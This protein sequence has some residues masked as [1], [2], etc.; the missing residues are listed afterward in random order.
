MNWPCCHIIPSS[1]IDFIS[2][3]R[4]DRYNRKLEKFH[5]VTAE[6]DEELSDLEEVERLKQCE[7]RP[8]HHFPPLISP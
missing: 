3:S 4:K 6:S 7:A 5:V 2:I 1:H 8:F